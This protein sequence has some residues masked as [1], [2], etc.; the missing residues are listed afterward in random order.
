MEEKKSSLRRQDRHHR[1][2]ARARSL[3]TKWYQKA[4]TAQQQGQPDGDPDPKLLAGKRTTNTDEK[5]PHQLSTKQSCCCGDEK[6][7]V[8]EEAMKAILKA[9]YTLST[10][11]HLKKTST[12]Y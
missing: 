12:G 9:S 2:A 7:N 10:S 8:N 5:N 11:Q 1:S 3:Q 6:T 4:D